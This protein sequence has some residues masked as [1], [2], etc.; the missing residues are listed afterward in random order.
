MRFIVSGNSMSP[1][2]TEGDRLFVSRLVLKFSRPEV[3]DYVVLSDPRTDRLILKKIDA[4]HGSEYFVVGEN[5]TGS[6]DSRTFGSVG[7]SSIVGK[8]LFRYKRGLPRVALR[9]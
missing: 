3:G 8:V 2:F 9:G 7:R 4:I 5:A 6:T 1:K